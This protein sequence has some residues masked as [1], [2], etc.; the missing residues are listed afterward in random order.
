M[1]GIH[2]LPLDE[3]PRERLARCGAQALS[4]EELLAIMLGTGSKTAP[5]L[6]LSR[7]LI[8][9]FETLENLFHASLEELES[10]QGIGMSKSKLLKAAFT[11]AER[12]LGQKEGARPKVQSPHDA[13][14]L[15][16][17]LIRG[18]KREHFIVLLL[19][20]KSR[21]IRAETVSIGILNATLVHPREVFYPAIKHKAQSVIALHNHPSGDLTPSNEDIALTRQLFH[22]A[23]CMQIPLFDHLIITES[24]F[25]SLKENLP[26][27]FR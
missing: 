9:H 10:F 14:R 1:E 13:F 25:L 19:D 22:A 12:A 18:E 3:R 17:P 23:T 11:L 16:A 21:L 27:L 26:E 7:Q 8:S 6:K 20:V 24:S 15:A 5:V 2:S 4:N